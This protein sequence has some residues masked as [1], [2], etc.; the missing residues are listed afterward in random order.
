MRDCSSPAAAAAAAAAATAVC[1]AK[2]PSL[3]NVTWPA[4]CLPNAQGVGGRS[5]TPN[6]PGYGN[7]PE[8]TI[9]TGT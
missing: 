7:L 8:L 3:P 2:L 1:W 6:F 5:V 4:D 9:C